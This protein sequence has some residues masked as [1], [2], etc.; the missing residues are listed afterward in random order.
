MV[1]HKHKTAPSTPLNI[2]WRTSFG[3]E[4]KVTVG[5]GIC[6]RAGYYLSQLNVGRNV[7][8]LKQPHLDR[9]TLDAIV[10]DLEERGHDPNVMELPDGEACKSNATLLSV[11]QRLQKLGFTRQDTMLAIGGGAITDLAG[12]AASTYLRGI[13][14]VLVPTTLLAQVDAAIGGKTAINLD[15]G[16]N[17]AGTFYFPRTIVVDPETLQTLPRRQFVSGLAE[18]VKYGMLEKTIAAET[19]YKPGPIPLIDF[20]ENSL[21]K[22]F[23]PSDPIMSG[24]IMSSIKMKLAVVAKDPHEDGLRRCLNL[25]HTVGHGVEKGSSYQLTHG[26][27]V[28]IGLAFASQLAV[29]FKMLSEK[30]ATRTITLL[31]NVELPTSIPSDLKLEAITEALFH[32]K[33]RSG[34]SFKMVIPNGDLGTVDYTKIVHAD[35]LTTY[36]EEF[37]AEK[38]SE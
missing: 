34:K 4:S 23:S 9:E 20:L 11:W 14:L 29:K 19:E 10:S 33:K 24:I 6:K 12:F 32:D 35:E 16:K 22:D 7:L 27:A 15:A 5:A 18:V 28:S 25:G 38:L 30:D 21:S 26:E 13:N 37:I 36:V 17:L 3:V 1:A 8:I 2:N 31:K